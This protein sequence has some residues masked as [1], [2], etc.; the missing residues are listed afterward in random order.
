V[1]TGPFSLGADYLQRPVLIVFS[2][3]FATEFTSAAAP[4]TVLHAATVSPLTTVAAM[5][6]SRTI[7]VLRNTYGT[8]MAGLGAPCLAAGVAVYR[9]LG[10]VG[11]GINVASSAADSVAGSRRKSGADNEHSG[12]PLNHDFLSFG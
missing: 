11:D 6:K 4:R 8:T 9:V 7:V 1:P 12:N 5:T 10:A 3:Q 2:V